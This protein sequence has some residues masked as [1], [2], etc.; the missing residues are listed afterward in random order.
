MG[1][2]LPCL[3]TTQVI[4]HV[5]CLLRH[6]GTDTITSQLL[7]GTIELA[8]VEVGNSDERFASSFDNYGH[9]LTKSWIKDVW[10]ELHTHQIQ[11]K[12]KTDLL[13]L[14]RD[15]DVFLTEQFL[16]KGYPKSHLGLLN[17]CRLYLWVTTQFDITS[18]D[19]CYLLPH[20]TQRHNPLQHFSSLQWPHQE[21]PSE[22]AWLIWRKAI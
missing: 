22:K 6:G 15:N 11:V 8:K 3:Y 7:D 21:Y 17:Q 13:R 9:L 19:G 14:L 10:Y 1:L 16:V 18:G 20:V 5:D 12:K 2:E 4:E